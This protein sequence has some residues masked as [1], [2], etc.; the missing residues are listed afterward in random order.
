M[1]TKVKSLIKSG[2][3]ADLL[4]KAHTSEDP[5]LLGMIYRKRFIELV[6]E[7]PESC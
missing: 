2:I 1:N 6:G 3:E 4:D 7:T 5:Q